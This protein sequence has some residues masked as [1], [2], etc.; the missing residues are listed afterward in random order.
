M[1]QTHLASQCKIDGKGVLAEFG[2]RDGN[3]GKWV[4]IMLAII[5]GYRILAWAVT[6]L[7]KT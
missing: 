5:A 2:Y 3:V 6:Y 4:G 1:Y 7:R